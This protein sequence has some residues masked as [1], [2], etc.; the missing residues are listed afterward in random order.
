[1]VE[2]LANRKLYRS[3]LKTG[4][5]DPSCPTCRQKFCKLIPLLDKDTSNTDTMEHSIDDGDQDHHISREIE[6]RSSPL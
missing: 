6:Y 3:Q 1:M 4:E 5:T 2:Y